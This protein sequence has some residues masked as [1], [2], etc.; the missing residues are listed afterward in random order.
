MARPIPLTLP[1]RDARAELQLRLENAPAEHAEAMLAA[2]EVLQGLY[3]R[4]VLDLARGALGSSDTVLEIAVDAA[5]SPQSIRSIR[6]L[7]LLVNMLGAIDP[8]TLGIVTR[9]VPQALQATA[10][11]QEPPGLWKLM[12]RFF[13]N[14]NMRRGLSAFAALLETLG[15]NLATRKGETG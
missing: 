12:T 5:Q 15:S 9:S 13:W 10:R 2:Y 11:Q 7:L 8:E 14:R 6:N 4:G 3:E 1:V